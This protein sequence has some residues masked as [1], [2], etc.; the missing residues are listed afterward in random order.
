[1]EGYFKIKQFEGFINPKVAAALK[2]YFKS[3]AWIKTQKYLASIQTQ[4]SK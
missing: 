4:A 1:L 2:L 3:K